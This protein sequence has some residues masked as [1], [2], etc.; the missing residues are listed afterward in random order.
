[1]TR[2]SSWKAM[3]S[4]IGGI[5]MHKSM[6]AAWLVMLGWPVVAAAQTEVVEYYHLDAIGSVRAVTDVHGNVVRR[7]DYYPFGVEYAPPPSTPDPLRFTG[8]ER[9]VETGLDYFG[10]R[11]YAS[12]TGRFTTVDPVMNIEAALLNPQRWNRY[13]YA[14]NNPLVFIDPD[15]RDA[16]VA[17]HRLLDSLRN[18]APRALS[19]PTVIEAVTSPILDAAFGPNIFSDPGSLSGETASFLSDVGA[20][21]GMNT[22]GVANLINPGFDAIAYSKGL[23]SIT[24]LELTM[25]SGN[26]LVG[27]LET[28]KAHAQQVLRA[29]SLG[30]VNLVGQ[31]ELFIKAANLDAASLARFAACRPGQDL[32]SLSRTGPFKS[33]TVFTKN[34]VVVIRDGNIGIH[35]IPK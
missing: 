26:S 5:N 6:V 25:F 33:I 19:I 30:Q 22:M 27:P 2:Q 34:G 23:T 24:P 16:I 8:K 11:Y 31:V 14:N 35:Q 12:R 17:L 20:L 21:K 4:E 15:G 10:A 9:D 13:A 28:A 18:R 7:H 29:S 1:M 3:V 32:A